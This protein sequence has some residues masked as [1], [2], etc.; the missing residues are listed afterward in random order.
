MF[1][2]LATYLFSSVNVDNLF[3]LRT[4]LLKNLPPKHNFI[5]TKVTKQ[6]FCSFDEAVPALL[7]LRLPSLRNIEEI[8]KFHYFEVDPPMTQV[9]DLDY[10]IVP[11]LLIFVTET[12]MGMVYLG[13]EIDNL[14]FVFN[15]VW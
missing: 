6:V 2:K 10:F 13:Y 4:V 7:E 11:A 14:F 1:D 5:F 12:S 3:P 9:T 8:S 15:R